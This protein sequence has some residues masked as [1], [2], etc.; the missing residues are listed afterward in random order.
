MTDKASEKG[1]R[2]SRDLTRSENQRLKFK[3]PDM[4]CP[5]CALTIEKDISAMPGVKSASV[6]FVK[7]SLTVDGPGAKSEIISARVNSLGYT[8]RPVREKQLRKT[9]LAIPDMD[10][11]D[12]ERIIRKALSSLGS[13]SDLQFNL[14]EQQVTIFHSG[15][16]F[17]LLDAMRIEGFKAEVI[18]AGRPI[19][20]RALPVWRIWIVVTAS[21]LV[22]GGGLLHYMGVSGWLFKPIILVGVMVGGWRIGH[23][24]LIAARR[25][26]LDMNFLMSAAVIG[27]I[28]IG[29]WVEAGT[30]I[31]LFAIAQILESY[32]LDRSRR[33]IKGLMELSPQT[34]TVIKDGLEKNIP[35]EEIEIGE[36]VLV[37]P[38]GKIPVDGKIVSGASSINQSPITGESLPVD[39]T[40]GDIVYAATIN[41]EGALEIEAGHVA[42]DTTLASIIRLV[43]E[44]QTQ[45]APSQSFV[46]RFAAIYT[47]SVVG[48]ASI[49][50]VIPPLL[51]GGAWPDWIYRSLA[52]LVIACPCALVISTPVTIVSALAGAARKGVLIKGGAFIENLHKIPAIAFDKTGTITKGIPA[53][54]EVIALNAADKDEVI[55][56]AA[57]IESRSEHP[58]A[59]AILKYA[60]KSG[61]DVTV[62]SDFKSIPGRGAYGVLNG[63]KIY[64]GNHALI[65][66]LGVCDGTTEEKLNIL[67][68]KSQSAVLVATTEKVL[69]IIAIADEI[70]PDSASAISELKDQGVSLIAMLTGDN[71]RTAWAVGE[72][73]GIEKIYAELLPEQ[74]VDAINSMKSK[75]GAVVMVGDGINDAPALASSTI[76]IAMGAAGSDIA[77]ETAD[78]ALMSDEP[79]K[80][81]WAYRLSKKAYGIITANI[82]MAITIKAIFVILAVMGLATLW[83]AVFADMGVSLMVI[84]NGM[85]ALRSS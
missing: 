75:S 76:G 19:K 2:R 26:R 77:L 13:V 25:L 41:G 1:Q 34:A 12:E 56:L 71:H 15:E 42:G 52:L 29:E 74:K 6:D 61:I 7:G 70:R 45:R 27:A 17:T 32:S 57:S 60:E 43:E 50:A 58:I 48:I 8:A 72:E 4:D 35:V 62:P 30:V 38:G 23:K 55:R 64:L 22:F 24:G 49:L 53:V 51:F 20:D 79:A 11:A 28:I 85:R 82:A 21:I 47:P 73:V 14:V 40:T 16:T 44:A 3:I 78:I 69:G 37:K 83:M 66:D 39:K 9:V 67:E 59:A 10:C 84:I 46:D 18:E 81:P 54:R 65:E 36:I 5:D 31:I 63:E 33:A 80:I 68:N